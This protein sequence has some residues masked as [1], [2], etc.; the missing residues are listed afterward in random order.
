MSTALI[1]TG[2]S[3]REEAPSAPV[4]PTWVVEDFEALWTVIEQS[5]R[6]PAVA[7][8]PRSGG[9]VGVHIGA[10]VAAVA[11]WMAVQS[12]G[13]E[14]RDAQYWI[15]T[16]DMKR[17]PE[18]GCFRETYRAEESIPAEGLPERFGGARS[19]STAIHFLLERGEFSAFHRIRSDEIWHFYDGHPLRLHVLGADGR[20]ESPLLGRDPGRG[21]RLQVVVPAGAWFAAEVEDDGAFALVGCTVA[22]G[23]DF[24]DFEMAS[25]RDLLAAFPGQRERIV[26]LVRLP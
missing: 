12:A 10:P 19:F 22:P 11:G 1:L 9:G 4:A 3:K 20:L 16:L 13:G 18:G 7:T 17:H 15:R 8:G 23:F 6:V 24:A 26:R 25:C 2:V 21:Q 14:P 5:N